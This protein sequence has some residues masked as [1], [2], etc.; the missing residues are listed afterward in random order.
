MC[1]HLLFSYICD[2]CSINGHMTLVP[3]CKVCKDYSC[4]M[5]A[6]LPVQLFCLKLVA[7]VDYNICEALAHSKYVDIATKLQ[8]VHNHTSGVRMKMPMQP[9]RVDCKGYTGYYVFEITV[10]IQVN[11]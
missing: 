8:D 5:N 2:I 11:E 6:Q 1:V 10:P 7:R 9:L 3:R 4:S